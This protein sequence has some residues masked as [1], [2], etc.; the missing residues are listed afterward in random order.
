MDG[1]NTRR[2]DPSSLQNT[3]S[4]WTVSTTTRLSIDSV[5]T[6]VSGPDRFPV[7]G[8]QGF[9]SLVSVTSPTC[10][11]TSFVDTIPVVSGSTYF[12][13]TTARPPPPTEITFGTDPTRAITSGLTP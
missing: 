10:S 4:S 13:L 1:K 5:T 2:T 3:V 7:C 8:V 9:R 11:S 6:G 12:S